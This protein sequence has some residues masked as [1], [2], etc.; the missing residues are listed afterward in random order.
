MLVSVKS[1]PSQLP[2]LGELALE[3]KVIG[4]SGVPSAMRVPWT[5]KPE[6]VP[7]NMISV[8]G[9]IVRVT[10]WAIVMGPWIT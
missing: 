8:P 5:S 9:E 4:C 2:L 1:S 10:P 6:F 3:V 7:S